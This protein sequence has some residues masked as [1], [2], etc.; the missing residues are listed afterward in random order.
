MVVCPSSQALKPSGVAASEKGKVASFSVG[1][2]HFQES[3]FRHALGG[4]RIIQEKGSQ[5]LRAITCPIVA[6]TEGGR[7]R[8]A[9]SEESLNLLVDVIQVNQRFPRVPGP[10]LH[11][12]RGS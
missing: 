5:V 3:N 4:R 8:A 1:E 11:P 7:Q 6:E 10:A 2:K 12:V 9:E